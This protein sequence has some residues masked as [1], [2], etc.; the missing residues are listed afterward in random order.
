MNISTRPIH[1]MMKEIEKFNNRRD[2]Q[3]GFFKTE[4]ND[5][6]KA[7]KWENTTYIMYR[8]GISRPLTETTLYR[9]Y[10]KTKK[11]YVFN[12]MGKFE[13]FLKEE[14][15][16]DIYF[17]MWNDDKFSNEHVVKTLLKTKRESRNNRYKI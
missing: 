16:K 8:F 13:N 9:K 10:Y 7:K 15:S 6:K 11:F 1:P 17:K 2:Q 12:S 3:I 5:I 14:E 4:M